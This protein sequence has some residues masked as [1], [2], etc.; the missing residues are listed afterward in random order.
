MRVAAENEAV[1]MMI[2]PLRDTVEGNVVRRSI[3]CRSASWANLISWDDGCGDEDLRARDNCKGKDAWMIELIA[4]RR[5]RKKLRMKCRC[6]DL[7]MVCWY[8]F[9]QI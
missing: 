7:R 3:Q 9:L 6:V 2:Q 4:E 1:R 8:I 5:E